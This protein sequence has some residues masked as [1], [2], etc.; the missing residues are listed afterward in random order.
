MSWR[1]NLGSIHFHNFGSSDYASDSFKLVEVVLP[2]RLERRYATNMKG[3]MTSNTDPVIEPCCDRTLDCR[4]ASEF[5]LVAPPN[6]SRLE[7]DKS[8]PEREAAFQRRRVNTPIPFR[9]NPVEKCMFHWVM[10]RIFATF[11]MQPRLAAVQK[12]PFHFVNIGFDTA[13]DLRFN[14]TL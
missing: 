13:T 2:S 14:I 1:S 12:S 10:K 6:R 9:N 5:C 3:R 7:S 8:R 4:A 11:I